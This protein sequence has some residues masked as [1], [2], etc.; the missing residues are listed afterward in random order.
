[1]NGERI[2]YQKAFSYLSIGMTIPLFAFLGFIVGR[3]YGEPGW[4]IAVGTLLGVGIFLADVLVR[5][6][7]ESQRE[8]TSSDT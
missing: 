2:D 8:G 5:A 6:S 3:E 1:L 7:R 4:G